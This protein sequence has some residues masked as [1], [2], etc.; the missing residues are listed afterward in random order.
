MALPKRPAY[1]P[2]ARGTALASCALAFAPVAAG[3]N[4]DTAVVRFSNRTR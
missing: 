1:C 3:A 4:F 2:A